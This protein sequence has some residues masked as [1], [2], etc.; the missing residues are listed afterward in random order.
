MNSSGS[1][2]QALDCRRVVDRIL[3]GRGDSLC[4]RQN[5]EWG[6]ERD[7]FLKKLGGVEHG[8]PTG[9]SSHAACDATQ[10]VRR[11]RLFLGGLCDS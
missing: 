7:D 5:F 10:H 6:Q 4:L 1:P 2:Q 3:P 11:R 8:F 9:V